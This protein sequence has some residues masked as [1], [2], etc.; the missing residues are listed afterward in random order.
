MPP[1][2]APQRVILMLRGS[3]R[4]TRSRYLAPFV[5]ELG[6][7]ILHELVPVV[8]EVVEARVAAALDT[9]RDQAR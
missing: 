1:A 9:L 2:H 8:E 6:V 7:H 5:Y 4:L 3:H